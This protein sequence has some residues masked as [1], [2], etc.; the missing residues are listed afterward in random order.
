MKSPFTTLYHSQRISSL[1]MG[2]LK[3]L[4]NMIIIAVLALLVSASEIGLRTERFFYDL[5]VTH[6]NRSLPPDNIMIIALDEITFDV[7]ADE[8]NGL[9]WP[10]PRSFHAK[11]LDNLHQ[12]GAKA[13][14]LDF[15]FDLE[16]GYGEDDDKSLVE[17]LNK[18]PTILAAE[19]N[20]KTICPPLPL[21][22]ESGAHAGNSSSPV[23]MDH[24]IREMRNA[25]KI[26]STFQ[27]AV[28]YYS[29]GIF[30]QTS[31]LETEISLPSVE[32]ALYQIIHPGKKRPPAG[33]IHF[34]GPPDSFQTVSWFEVFNSDLFSIHKDAFKDKTVF[35][36]KTITASVTPGKQSDIFSVP[37]GSALMAG[38]EIRA[39]AYAT[40]AEK[41]T[42]YLIND[43]YFPVTFF[44]YVILFSFLVG[45]TKDVFICFF[46]F[47][48]SILLLSS[49]TI[50]LY[51]NNYILIVMPFFVF[52]AFYY[53]FTIVTRYVDE[54][55]R[56]LL[57]QAQLFNYL[58]ERV[59]RHIMENPIGLAM[60][61]DRKVI[62]LLFADIAGFT[63]LS[64]A[65]SPEIVVPV[66]QEHLK[67]MTKAIF[68]HEGTLDKYLGDGIMAF[69]GAPEH[70]ENHADLALSAAAHMLNAL[71]SANAGRR[72]KGIEP[73]H[74]RI[75]LHT[76]EAVVGNI[77]SELF[78][79]YTAIGDN[80][81]TASRIEGVSKYFGTRITIS[82]ACINALCG[83]LPDN[84]FKL[85]RVAVKGK[86]EP[87]LL[88]TLST[89]ETHQA[90][91]DLKE[92]LELMEKN[93]YRK[94]K[95][96]L[97]ETLEIFPEFGP[98]LFHDS[99]FKDNI[100]PS[101]DKSGKPYWKLEGK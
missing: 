11:V 47:L 10:Y 68:D 76:G 38:V 29:G 89:P 50:F 28:F 32:S 46:V 13:V 75:G 63:T 6:M 8:M 39:N 85:G 81:N 23:D 67:D 41:K 92:C 24:I 96:R 80:V 45:R 17:S 79:D 2:H 88:Y 62:T 14:F 73:L 34:F 93:D 12:A 83:Q 60:A 49:L 99:K 97:S 59:A 95:H 22:I 9:H 71:D 58:P 54:R 65:L 44:L 43:V 7:I 64:E 20:E 69:W 16:S 35:I 90:F 25:V 33:Y 91:L 56:R 4:L 27:E 84:L 51:M 98:A 87:L 15:I 36:G 53:I 3:Y 66:L 19:Y 52:S 61:G 82:D 21:F 74:M 18:I 42:K 72:K 77:G 30:K 57:T 101:L 70:Q 31:R 55:D 37:Y 5:N 86:K 1:K 48:C 94:A 78:I 40:L 26:P 100:G